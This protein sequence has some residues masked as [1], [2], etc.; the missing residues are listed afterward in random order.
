VETPGHPAAEPPPRRGEPPADWPV[1]AITAA[2]VLGVCLLIVAAPDQAGVFINRL[3]DLVTRYC[4]FLYQW[5][6]IALLVFLGYLAFSRYGAIRL[7]GRDCKPDYST[8]SWIG[9]VFC[10]GVGATLIYWATVEWA[11]YIDSPPLGAEP[12]S[13]AAI[14]WAATYG[15]FHWGPVGW[16]IFCL[17]TIAISYAFYM[18]GEPHLR[19]SAGC[20]PFLPG[21]VGSARGRL[22]DFI[23]MVNVIGGSATSLGLTAPMI[24]AM[25][26]KVS[27][28]SHDFA[29]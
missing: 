11:Y 8:L 9:M 1:F 19:L 25:Y 10:S 26:A 23:Y 21:G 6:V 28:V 4:G 2:T 7:G 3:Y 16:A 29:L 24:A 20:L 17:P 12:R 22:I 14:E 27:G 15:M 13:T 5:Y 18:R